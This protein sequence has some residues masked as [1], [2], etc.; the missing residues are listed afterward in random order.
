MISLVRS[1][2]ITHSPEKIGELKCLK[3][4]GNSFTTIEENDLDYDLLLEDIMKI[5]HLII[6]TSY[7]E[8]LYHEFGK[9]P[10]RLT[11]TTAGEVVCH[12]PVL[13]WPIDKKTTT[14]VYRP[15][16]DTEVFYAGNKV[17]EKSQGSGP[18]FAI[19]KAYKLNYKEVELIIDWKRGVDRHIVERLKFLQGLQSLSEHHTEEDFKEMLKTC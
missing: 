10:F 12:T 16:F 1:N 18:F 17:M 19:E 2:L 4:R 6:P 13:N 5:R 3:M 9:E 15:E 11:V 7:I 14:Q 8:L